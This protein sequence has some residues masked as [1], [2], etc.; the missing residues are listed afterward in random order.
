MSVHVTLPKTDLGIERGSLK[1]KVSPAQADQPD[2]NSQPLGVAG[3][4]K[5]K[6]NLQGRLHRLKSDSAG[7]S[8]N[9]KE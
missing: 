9:P 2:K 1:K 4:E 8:K 3:Y 7:P 5:A 6:A